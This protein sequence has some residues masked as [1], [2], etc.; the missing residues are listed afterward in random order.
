MPVPREREIKG[1][2]RDPRCVEVTHTELGGHRD[3][4]RDM[5]NI[6][7]YEQAKFLRFYDSLERAKSQWRGLGLYV[8]RLSIRP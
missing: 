4:I 3:D 1:C 5:P 2:D 8:A 6:S 7:P